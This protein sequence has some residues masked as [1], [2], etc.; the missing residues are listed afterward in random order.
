MYFLFIFLLKVFFCSQYSSLYF[1]KKNQHLKHSMHTELSLTFSVSSGNIFHFNVLCVVFCCIDFDLWILPCFCQHISS[2][3]TNLPWPLTLDWVSLF[4]FTLWCQF[5]C[6]LFVFPL[7]FWLSS[8]C[9]DSN[10]NYFLDHSFSHIFC[11]DWDASKKK[12]K[13]KVWFKSN[14]FYIYI[15]RRCLIVSKWLIHCFCKNLP[16]VITLVM[17]GSCLSILRSIFF[18]RVL[19]IQVGIPQCL[20]GIMLNYC[21]LQTDCIAHTSQLNTLLFSMQ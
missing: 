11:T 1:E 17:C 12:K 3:C 21:T 18:C 13:K 14:K 9:R 6:Q 10:L 2:L 7:C 8:L 16:A 19:H 4:C 5:L 20:L 15:A